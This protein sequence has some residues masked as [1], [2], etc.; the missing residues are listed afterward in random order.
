MDFLSKETPVTKS[1]H[2]NDLFDTQHI[3]FTH[4]V[5][6]FK[7]EFICKNYPKNAIFALKIDTL[8][9]NYKHMHLIKQT[10][11]TLM[12]SLL[13]VAA[14]RGQSPQ[15]DSLETLLKKHTRIDTAKVH[16]LNALVYASYASDPQKAK[17]YAEQSRDFSSQLNDP[18]G[19]AASLWVT[20]L[21]LMRENKKEAL[22]H[23]KAALKI[24]QEIGDKAEM[25]RYLGSIGNVSK[26]LGDIKASTAAH[27]QAL[28]IALEINN[29]ELIFS[30]KINLAINMNSIGEPVQAAQY[31][32]DA[33]KIATELNQKLPLA[34]AY[35]NLGSIHSR[36]GNHSTALEYYL[37]ALQ[38]NEK[39]NDYQSTCINL[40]NIAGVQS[41]QNEFETA[42]ATLNK[43][44]QL[45]TERQD[46]SRMTCCFANLGNVYQQMKSPKA[47]GYFQ[48]SLSMSKYAPIGQ[49][50]NVLTNIGEIYAN[51]G[52][53]AAAMGKFDE[54]LALA[55]KINIKF[56]LGEIYIKKG[57]FYLNQKKYSPA[58][59]DIQ[60][61]LSLAKEIHYTELQ[62]DCHQ[63]LSEIDAATGD[64]KNAYIQYIEYKA[65]CDTLLNE[66]DTRK[67]ALLESS[68]QF[69]KEREVYELEKSQQALR[70][71]N[72]KQAIL[73]LVVISLL[74]LLLSFAIYWSGRLRKRVLRLE[75]ENMNRELEA[76][77]KAM[78]VAQLK[79]VQN[80]ER[81]AHAIKMLEDIGK[82]TVGVEHKNLSSLINDYKF[83]S[84]HSNWE[85]FE[86]LF[87]KV[88]T[89]FW[90]KLN[91]LCP[92]LTPN[93]RKLCVFLKLNMNSKDIAL[94]TLQSEEAL[95]KSRLRLR[96][97]FNLDRSVNLST[98][99]HNL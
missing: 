54:A 21:T 46:S 17:A 84:N 69:A 85:E 37:L 90:E 16:L 22:D 64:F 19:K 33:I 83:Q 48:K 14:S 12:A 49:T 50:I 1:G 59:N 87:T 15:I 98:F 86:T 11:T 47:L 73:S 94:I 23:F 24:A 13:F 39:E 81:D 72:Q 43:A 79:L 8:H 88:N 40:I 75:I 45:S 18:K 44:L 68:Y 66:K 57:I 42:L 30:T 32:Q 29:N 26:E 60:K 93:E 61:A 52:E 34:K 2:R 91:E 95:K 67:I 65:L 62:K 35:G 96:K 97:K 58:K 63:R 9:A 78:A 92:T 41:A 70:I 82:S 55:Q 53:S 80:S 10:L 31:L 5:K 71:Q 25:S 89:P 36:M 77:Q 74:V 51:S 38:L 20:G 3:N 56:A 99:I 27:Q 76:N 28:Q 7:L 4:T 6:P